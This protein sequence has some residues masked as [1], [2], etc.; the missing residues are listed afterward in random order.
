MQAESRPNLVVVGRSDE[1]VVCTFETIVLLAWKNLPSVQGV[2]CCARA[3][4]KLRAA[5]PK[6]RLGF[7]TLIA[8]R[9]QSGTL[10]EP[11]RRALG[12]TLQEYE[13][14]IGSAV[15]AYE[16]AGFR[17]T[18]VR[19][20]ITA[21]NFASRL[22]FPTSVHSHR[23][24]AAERLLQELGPVPRVTTSYIVSLLHDLCA[25]SAA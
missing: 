25:Q 17:A 21:I 2:A 1:Y 10:P 7:Y 4:A 5:R 11:V 20:V 19:S 23:G 9:A 6:E 13:P 14:N 16:G 15:I 8:E 12:R 18:I 3:F 24:A 22:Q